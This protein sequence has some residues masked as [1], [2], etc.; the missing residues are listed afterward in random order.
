M[1]TSTHDHD[2]AK[3]QSVKLSGALVREAEERAKHFNRSKA[4]QIEF[5]ARIGKIAEENRD[6]S[7][8]M[9]MQI[10]LSKEEIKNKETT[11]FKFS[12]RG[13]SKSVKKV[14]KN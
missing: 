4:G 2:Q 3:A 6:I 10:L 1:H 12:S 7:F 11:P 5:W 8:D 14:P 13:S 9:I